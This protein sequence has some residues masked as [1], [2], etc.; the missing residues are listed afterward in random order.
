MNPKTPNVM[1]RGHTVREDEYGRWNLND[2]WTLAKAPASKMP[3]HWRGNSAS[4][5]LIAALQK[6]V[7]TSYLLKG[8]HNT[9]VIHAECPAVTLS[10][11]TPSTMKHFDIWKFRLRRNGLQG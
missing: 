8:G 7:T 4:K 10:E 5:E 9:P 11:S 3:K 6:K 1:L 2:I